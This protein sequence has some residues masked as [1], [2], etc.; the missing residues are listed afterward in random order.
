MDDENKPDTT[1][2]AASKRRVLVRR[3]SR[4]A[5]EDPLAADH[6]ESLGWNTSYDLTTPSGHNADSRFLPVLH[7][8]EDEDFAS[9]L[10]LVEKMRQDFPD[11]PRT[12][13]DVEVVRVFN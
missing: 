6:A 5:G 1:P 10:S 4:R 3:H 2:G 12:D 7:Y 9:N 8:V 11:R 13:Y